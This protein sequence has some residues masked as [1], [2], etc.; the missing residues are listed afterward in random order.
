MIILVGTHIFLYN[1]LIVQHRVNTVAQL[2][3]TPTQYGV[4]LD[5]RDKYTELVLQH[6][7]LAPGEPWKMY[8]QAYNHALLI[9]NVKAEGIEQHIINDLATV[10]CTNYFLL[11]VSLPQLV[12][13]SNQGISNL[14]VRYSEYEPIEL[15]TQFIGKVQWVW[16]DWFSTM[17][18]QLEQYA[19]L[20]QHYKLCLVS[21]ELQGHSTEFIH[22]TK[23]LLHNMPIDA[24]C[25]KHPQLWL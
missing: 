25:T 19:Y 4:E 14:A 5:V 22:S 2:Y 9:A 17:P 15:A 24:V 23:Q 18:L 8:L 11:D 1:M 6:D 13:L 10:H 3:A 12:K 21:P 7:A 20:K 16:V